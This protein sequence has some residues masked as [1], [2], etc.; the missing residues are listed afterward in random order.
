MTDQQRFDTIAGWGYDYMITPNMDRIANEG[1]SFRQAYCP[2]AT[3]IASR[4]AIFTGMYAHNTGAYSFDHWADQRNWV[5]DLADN[6]YWC[7]NIGKMHFSPRDVPGG[8]HERI[9]VENPTNRTHAMGGADDDWGRYLSFHG[10]T[11]PND[12]TST[13]PDWLEKHQG[14]PWHLE[15]RFHSDVF[16]GDSAVAWIDNYQGDKPLFL[17]V[18]LTGPHEPWDPLPRHLKLYQDKEMPPRYL[19][20]GELAEKPPQH[21]AHLEFHAN[22]GHE[23]QIDLRSASDDEIAE[24]KRHYFAKIT[25]V[26]EQVGRVLDSLEA[27]GWLENSLLIFCSDHGEMLGDHGL[28]YKWLMY[29]PIVHIPLIIRHPGSVGAPCEVTDLVSLM[30]LGPTILDAAG[31]DVPTNLE[32]RSLLPYL[33]D[34]A[35]QP[36]EVCLLRGQLPDHDALQDPQAGL[37]HRP[38]TGGTLRSGCRST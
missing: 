8:F 7:V 34:E 6:G 33:N 2:G 31:V 37:L 20:E 35:I 36:R 25:T 11:R 32:G 28:A 10:Q 22:T 14:V 15:E 17:Q 38:G 9:I 30:D 29:D 23:S 13:D 21:Q 26:D 4:A 24:M 18:G 3:C 27:R 12:R 5:Q 16:I 1:V 19:K